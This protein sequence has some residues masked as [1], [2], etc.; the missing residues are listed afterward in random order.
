M[1]VNELVDGKFSNNNELID[2]KVA[3]FISLKIAMEPQALAL[4]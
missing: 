4:R 1:G 2:P 3:D